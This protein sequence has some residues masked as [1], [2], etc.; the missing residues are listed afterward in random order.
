MSVSSWCGET[1]ELNFDGSGPSECFCYTFFIF[2]PSVLFL[3]YVFL[4]YTGNLPS[5]LSSPTLPASPQ[6]QQASRSS[7]ISQKYVLWILLLGCF[8]QPLCFGIFSLTENLSPAKITAIGLESFSWIT[9][10]ISIYYDF[11]HD[12]QWPCLGV[13]I[14]FCIS[15]AVC[16]IIVASVY[17]DQQ[18]STSF[19]LGVL[20]FLLSLGMLV[21]S[22]FKDSLFPP[23]NDLKYSPVY[24][25]ATNGTS[26]ESKPSFFERLL[27]KRKSSR[28]EVT[29]F[30]H[31]N[32]A[33]EVE[34]RHSDLNTTSTRWSHASEKSLKEIR[35]SEGEDSNR[36]KSISSQLSSASANQ[37]PIVQSRV[38]TRMLEQPQSSRAASA[39]N[40]SKGGLHGGLAPKGSHLR[41]DPQT[42]GGFSAAARAKASDNRNNDSLLPRNQIHRL[43]NLR[44]LVEKWGLRRQGYGHEEKMNQVGEKEEE[45]GSSSSQFSE[46]FS[47]LVRSDEDD[48]KQGSSNSPILSAV[49]PLDESTDEMRSSSMGGGEDNSPVSMSQ[50][51]NLDSGSQQPRRK[52][53]P[54]PQQQQRVTQQKTSSFSSTVPGAS[55]P[56]S[57]EAMGTVIS[58]L[59]HANPSDPLGTPM[60]VEF[61]ISFQT[62][63]ETEDMKPEK[64]V[65]WRTAKE[66]LSLHAVL[67]SITLIS[68][69]LTLFVSFSL[70]RLES[71]AMLLQ[72]DQSYKPSSLQTSALKAKL[73]PRLLS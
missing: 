7:K 26:P 16:V 46:R 51:S 12:L 34:N 64:W 41:Q 62:N 31:D 57:G 27:G 2:L 49:A 55:A 63:D 20:I 58:L 56:S 18:H 37:R 15:V 73:S 14:Y 6:Q 24:F 5:L 52:R 68:L 4:L 25:P 42:L 71:L 17:S 3:L 39:L 35:L 1:N 44:L 48:H 23:E 45:E 33:D 40:K 70:H 30:L 29:P 13:Q 54:Q 9:C 67:V 72:E 61:E 65:V 32:E 66:L 28:D 19:I 47:S 8:L 36:P 69:F 10:G 22:V 59:S 11:H 21:L 43:E 60:E 50:G 38:L 53:N